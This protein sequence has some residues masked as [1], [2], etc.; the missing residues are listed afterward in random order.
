MLSAL[1]HHESRCLCSCLAAEFCQYVAYVNADCLLRNA[2][3]FGDL[4][5]LTISGTDGTPRAATDADVTH[6]RWLW[7]TA[8]PAGGSRSVAFF[9]RVK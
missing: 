3:S 6:V 2:K 9:G 5:S 7:S 8:V 1:L 4:A